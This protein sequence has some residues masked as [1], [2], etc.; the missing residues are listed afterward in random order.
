MAWNNRD[1]VKIDSFFAADVQLL[2]ADNRFKGKTEVVD[3]WVRQSLPA[4]GNL[5]T[6]VVS[7]D[8]DNHFAYESGSFSVDVTAPN[9]PNAVGEGNYVFVW[10]KQADNSW[11]ISYIQL[12]DLPLQTTRR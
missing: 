4:I 7:S 1:S 10:K 2:Q 8:A 6:S 12:E 5:K 11:K 9:Q 3:K